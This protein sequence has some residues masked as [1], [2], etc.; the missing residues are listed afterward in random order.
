M[1]TNNI[2]PNK[3]L[4]IKM[5][6]E[7][8]QIFNIQTLLRIEPLNAIGRERIKINGGDLFSGERSI[9]RKTGSLEKHF[10]S[11]MFGDIKQRQLEFS[12]SIVYDSE[13]MT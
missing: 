7:L 2:G 3:G 4:Q 10:A 8:F 13:R 11:F 5:T 9:S 1:I 12:E 6:G